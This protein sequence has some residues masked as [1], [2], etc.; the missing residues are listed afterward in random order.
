MSRESGGM[1][2]LWRSNDRPGPETTPPRGPA[3]RGHCPLRAVCR[4][5]DADHLSGRRHEGAPAC[6]RACRPV[7]HFAYAAVRSVRTGCCGSDRQSLP[8]RCG[9]AGDV[10][11]EIHVLPQRAGRH[12]RRPDRDAARRRTL[13]DRRQCRQCGRGRSASA[14]ARRRL[15]LQGRGARPRVPGDPGTGSL[16][17]TRAGR[18]RD[19][20]RCCSCTASSRGRAGS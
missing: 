14:Q 15:R 3:R 17:S 9:G 13:H 7:R 6:P 18:R 4:L 8:A 11:V 1:R 16:G 5:V 10:A 2:A 20:R 12:H 19:R